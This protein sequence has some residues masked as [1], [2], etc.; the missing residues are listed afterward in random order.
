MIPAA[1][2]STLALGV[3]PGPWMTQKC[4]YRAEAHEAREG[5]DPEVHGVDNRDVAAIELG[6]ELG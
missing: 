1:I 3:V 2:L 4:T 5:D 6:E